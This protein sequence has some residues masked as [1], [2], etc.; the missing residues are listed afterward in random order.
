MV[1][2][3]RDERGWK[4]FNNPK[5]TAISLSLEAAELLELMQWRTGEELASHLEACQ[6]AVAHELSDILYWVLLLAHDLQ[7]DLARAFESKMQM[8]VAKYPI[9]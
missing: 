3:F 7:I 9:T 4:H 2:Q 1:I 8:N 6:E 5:D